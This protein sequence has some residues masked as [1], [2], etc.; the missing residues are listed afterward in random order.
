[1]KKELCIVIP[2]YN[3]EENIGPL[4]DEINKIKKQ[5]KIKISTL[6]IDNF[7]SDSTVQ[8]LEK[9]AKK[10]KS[11]RIIVNTRNFGT[12]RS[13]L[14]GILQAPG[15]AV[16][17]MSAD[18]QD[19]PH[20][21]LDFIKYWLKDFVVVLGV[22]PESKENS[23]LFSLRT[24]YYWFL[25]KI[26]DTKISSH[27]TGF[28]L[29]DRK[30][31]EEVRKTNDPY[32]FF[33]GL[34]SEFGFSLK[35]I[36]YEQPRRERGVSKNNFYTLYDSGILGIID[37]SLVPIRFLTFFGIFFGVLSF[38]A[39]TIYLILKIIYWD[40]FPMGTAPLMIS[41]FFIASLQFIFLG[42]IAEYVA[43]IYMRLKNRP[44]VVEHKRINFD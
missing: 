17:L 16:I 37:H 32:P 26:V 42:L 41:I 12:V 19:P 24:L 22:K 10:D 4:L 25:N 43:G 29:Y 39:A 27:A 23:F 34:V 13:P 31:V 7:S 36:K 28:G 40:S 6:F 11:I 5:T 15:D 35:T 18:L 9:K 3:E 1:M 30:F 8:E 21:I 2:C 33:R 14:H 20:L 38:F 44:G